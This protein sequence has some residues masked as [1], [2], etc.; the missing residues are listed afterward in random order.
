MKLIQEQ[1]TFKTIITPNLECKIRILCSEIN[2]VEWSGIVFYTTEG[3]FKDNNLT[4]IA[5]DL[6]LMHKG[7]AGYTEFEVTPDIATY[8]AMNDLLEYKIGLV[9][10]HNNMAKQFIYSIA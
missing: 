10:S 5:E 3:S 6:I 1:S 8:M 9:H 4:I 2:Q 7:T